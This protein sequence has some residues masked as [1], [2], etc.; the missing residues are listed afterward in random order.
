MSSENHRNEIYVVFVLISFNENEL[1]CFEIF[2]FFL[3]KFNRRD[4][5]IWR[6]FGCFIYLFIFLSFGYGYLFA[7]NCCGRDGDGD[8]GGFIM[9]MKRLENKKVMNFI[10]IILTRLT[11]FN[12]LFACDLNLM[13]FFLTVLRHL[14]PYTLAAR[15]PIAHSFYVYSLY[16]FIIVWW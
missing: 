16:T 5:T 6:G 1:F 3:L 10:I 14:L 8:R 12:I 11:S 4:V 13:Y 15:S 2:I 9:C 7:F